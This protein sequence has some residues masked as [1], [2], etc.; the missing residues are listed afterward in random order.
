MV[1]WKPGEESVPVRVSPGSNILTDQVIPVVVPFT[2]LAMCGS[3]RCWTLEVRGP[4]FSQWNVGMKDRL[5]CVGKRNG[6]SEQRKLFQG[7]L[8]KGEK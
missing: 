3:S 8:L 2:L 1:P 6:G 5:E 7:I 4:W